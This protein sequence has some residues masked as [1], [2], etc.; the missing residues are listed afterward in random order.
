VVAAARALG[1]EV[2]EVKEPFRWSEDFGYFTE[3]YRGAFFGLGSGIAQ[4]QLHDDAYDYPD[5]LIE[6][7]ARLYRAIIDRELKGPG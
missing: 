3:R 6:V 7:G 2:E 4:P 5:E 1:L